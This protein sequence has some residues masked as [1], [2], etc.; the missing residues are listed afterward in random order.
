MLKLEN[1]Y[2]NFL[3]EYPTLFCKDN[4]DLFFQKVLVERNSK[5]SGYYDLPFLENQEIFV[6]QT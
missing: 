6:I 5:L 2:Q 3:G 1:T 4:L